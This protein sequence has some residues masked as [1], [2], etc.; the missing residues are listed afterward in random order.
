MLKTTK[1]KLNKNSVTI[2]PKLCTQS[3]YNDYHYKLNTWTLRTSL[4]LLLV[5]M[6]K[7]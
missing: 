5:S 3:V 7:H 2:H 1:T 6:E 4:N